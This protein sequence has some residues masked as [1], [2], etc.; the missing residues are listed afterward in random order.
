MH[1]ML[2]EVL[3]WPFKEGITGAGV[4]NY[5]QKEA[6]QFFNQV[7][8]LILMVM[9]CVFQPIFALK[10]WLINKALAMAQ[11][12]HHNELETTSNSLKWRFGGWI[13]TKM[14]TAN[15]QDYIVS[16]FSL[17]EDIFIMAAWL[18]LCHNKITRCEKWKL[19]FSAARTCSAEAFPQSI[20]I[21]MCVKNTNK[22]AQTE[23]KKRQA[24]DKL[25]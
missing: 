7:G 24:D 8:L 1:R 17:E 13:A 18:W 9:P 12:L 15:S 2:P 19:S 11:F 6:T 3:D 16:A 25:T 21:F 20:D 4:G 5:S 14:M 23:S 22:D 10:I